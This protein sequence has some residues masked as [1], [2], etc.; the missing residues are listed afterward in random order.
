[1]NIAHIIL[2]EF[3]DVNSH[4]LSGYFVSYP[5]THPLLTVI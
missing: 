4:Q 1:M 2:F 5:E 3:A